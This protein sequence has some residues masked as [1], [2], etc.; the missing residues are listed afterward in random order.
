MEIKYNLSYPRTELSEARPCLQLSHQCQNYFQLQ[1]Q[2]VGEA[3]PNSGLCQEI[4]GIT[5]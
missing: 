4:D 2:F 3:Q 1:T 5:I